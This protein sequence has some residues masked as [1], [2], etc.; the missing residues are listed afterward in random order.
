MV[1]ASLISLNLCTFVERKL[2]TVELVL[3]LFQSR[4]GIKPNTEPELLIHNTPI[5]IK[6]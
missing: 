6:F 2:Y 3:K 1:F 5:L 4:Q